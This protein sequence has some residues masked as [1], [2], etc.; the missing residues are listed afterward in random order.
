MTKLML[1]LVVALQVADIATTYCALSSGKGAEGNGILAPLFARFGVLPSLLATKGVFIV[2]LLGCRYLSPELDSR[3]LWLG[4]L[5]VLA[6][7]YAAIIVNN[8]KV[9]L[10]KTIPPLTKK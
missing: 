8:M 9:L 5:G 3:P 10:A 7:G 4:T 6:V 2:W 1:F